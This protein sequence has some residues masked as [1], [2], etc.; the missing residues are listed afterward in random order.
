[1]KTLKIAALALCLHAP[2]S[3]AGCTGYTSSETR[4]KTLGI[5]AGMAIPGF[6]TALAGIGM[7]Y[8]GA[9]QFITLPTPSP[10]DA[11]RNPQGAA[12]TQVKR[13]LFTVACGTGLT[14]YG[15]TPM[16]LNESYARTACCN[17][18]NNSTYPN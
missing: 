16:I 17:A 9:Q 10:E 11:E 15:L 18:I 7:I 2:L 14:L 13:G 1:M 6:I 3:H 4:G 8:K 5:F 12:F